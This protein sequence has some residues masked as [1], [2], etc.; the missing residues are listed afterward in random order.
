MTKILARAFPNESY[1]WYHSLQDIFLEARLSNDTVIFYEV[2]GIETKRLTS[3]VVRTLFPLGVKFKDRP[4]LISENV[5]F[6][7]VLRRKKKKY[8]EAYKF[9]LRNLDKN[10]GLK[11]TKKNGFTRTKKNSFTRTKK[12]SFKRTK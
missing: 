4:F 12:S 7:T 10:T 6:Y 2:C 5:D 3:D 11:R 9:L 1:R 8:R